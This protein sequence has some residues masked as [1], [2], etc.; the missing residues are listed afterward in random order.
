MPLLLLGLV[1]FLAWFL[2]MLS[3]GG[4]PLVLIPLVSLWFGAQAVAPV[5]TVGM[6]LGNGQRSLF[7]WKHID[8]RLTL[9][10]I[11]GTLIGAILGAYA[12]TR[13]DITWLQAILGGL[14][15]VMALMALVNRSSIQI[16]IKAWHFLPLSLINSILSSLV[17]STGPIL[18]PIYLSYGLEKEDLI[19]TKAITVTLMHSL[20]LISYLAL[21]I[22]SWQY[23]GDGLVIGLAA[24][25]ANWLGKYV[26]Q[27]MSRQQF[28]HAILTFVALSGVLMLWE[29]RGELLLLM[30]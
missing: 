4:S 10:H 27:H 30:T 26:L 18:N 20:K 29:N 9:W 16:N 5:I 13:I 12:F 23:V 8:W 15:V 7:L 6:L 11:P 3:G 24:I 22:L 14:L 17:G 2:S 21:G 1:S 28:R 19:A 25:P